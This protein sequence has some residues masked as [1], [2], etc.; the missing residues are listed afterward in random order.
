VRWDVAEEVETLNTCQRD[1]WCRTRNQQSSIANGGVNEAVTNPFGR[2]DAG[3]QDL[4]KLAGMQ[5]SVLS[6]NLPATIL[7][8]SLVVVEGAE[9]S[10][11]L[12]II[13]SHS[14]STQ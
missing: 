8:S 11:R 9:V 3:V 6:L 2:L 14:I 13:K 12:L 4:L 10:V 5:D 7:L 1:K